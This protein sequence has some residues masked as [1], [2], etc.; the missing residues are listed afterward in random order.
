MRI[1][2]NKNDHLASYLKLAPAKT[3]KATIEKI[4]LTVPNMFLL[5]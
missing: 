1:A 3:P 4:A 2:V 5:R